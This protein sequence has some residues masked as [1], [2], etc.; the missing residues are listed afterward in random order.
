MLL[1]LCIGVAVAARALIAS[2]EQVESA[3]TAQK[4]LQVY[5]AFEADARQLELGNSEYAQWDDA[6]EFVHDGNA[7]FIA[8]NFVPDALSAV[9]VDVIWI[10]DRGGRELFSG[11][12]DRAAGKVVSPAPVE[13]LSDIRQFLGNERLMKLP[14]AERLVDT[15]HGLAMISAVEIKRTDRSEPTGA[16]M[17]FVRLVERSD[18]ERLRVL[19]GLPVEMID[20]AGEGQ[21]AGALPPSVRAWLTAR[22]DTA[23]TFV[24]AEDARHISGYALVR[25]MNHVPVALF[26]TRFPRDIYGLGYRTTWLMLAG[27][28]ALFVA[29][30]GAVLWLV[31]TLLRSLAARHSMEMRYKNVAAQLRDAILLVDA[32]THEIIE[33]NDAALCA[34]GCG[35]EGFRAQTVQD[36]F[37]GIA[38]VTLEQSTRCADR[39]VMESRM[40]RKD[41]GWADAEVTITSFDIDGRQL[42]TLMGHD[43]SQRKEAQEADHRYRAKLLDL[44]EHDSLTRLPNRLYLDSRLPK[45]MESVAGSGRL[46]ALLYVDIDHFKN[47][48]DSRGHGCGDRL[49]EVVAARLRTTVAMQDLVARMGGDEFV[50]VAPL[51]QDL[52]AVEALATRVRT[53]VNAPIAADDGLVTVTASVGIAMHPRDGSDGRTLLKHADIALHYAKDAGRNCHRFFQSDMD[54]RL[55]EHVALEQALRQATGSGQI[56]MVYQPV[57]D[58]RTGH[59]ASLEAL[60]RWQHPERGLIAPGQFIPVAEKSGLIVELGSQA[61]MQVMAQ[62]SQWLAA[63]E[64]LVPIA[65]NVS[66][67]QIERMDFAT[68]VFDLVKETGVDPSWLRFEITES[69]LMREPD[70]LIGVLKALRSIG[71]EILIDDFGTGYSSLNYLHRL[72]VDTLK[73]DRSFIQDLRRSH[74][75]AH[76]LSAMIEMA[77]KLGLKTVAEG[78]ETEE[79]ASLLRALG[80]DYAQGY[81]FCRPVSAERCRLLL[82]PRLRLRRPTGETTIVAK[83]ASG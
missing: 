67:L 35:R 7:R 29:F 4:A 19:T 21:S 1:T 68:L 37:P 69:A 2:F 59:I 12:N 61:L 27:V 41:G 26:A 28:V 70:R 38:A 79:Q 34:L 25:D 33:A 52:A 76:I 23:P 42:L 60:M 40:R 13:Y 53:A 43:I 8:T 80:C 58:L 78:V 83:I 5:R 32:T 48:N 14:P 31:L 39:M 51:A 20:L 45:V 50:I 49:L 81:Y 73:I 54:Q 65:V 71:T 47:I 15:P 30:G 57:I 64:P 63:G 55:S 75:G 46:L 17:L 3:I 16:T 22:G 77:H 74:A 56:F 36:L 44:V 82:R 11:F 24:L 9:R 66:P 72:P 18:I 10:V 6:V 62:M